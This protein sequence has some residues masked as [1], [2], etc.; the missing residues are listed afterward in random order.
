MMAAKHILLCIALLPMWALPPAHEATA[1]QVNKCHCI[2]RG[3][4]IIK[5][6]TLILI[7]NN[8]TDATPT[9]LQL[10]Q[11]DV[12]EIGVSIRIMDRIGSDYDTLGTH[13]LNDEDGGI[14]RTIEHDKNKVTG[15]ILNEVFHRWI[16]GQGQKNGKK[17]NTWEMLVKYLKHVKLMALADEIEAVLQ[18]CTEKTMHLNDEECAHEY[19]ERM[20]EALIETKSLQ[21]L[22]SMLAAVII[23]AAIFHCRRK[24]NTIACH[25]LINWKW[26]WGQGQALAI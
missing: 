8:S 3:K 10:T 9:M 19:G 16:K 2:K 4:P 15:K 14:M 21:Y 11:L 25:Q 24:L 26:A 13:L 6:S 20:H 12:L 23:G 5:V 22:I 18:F 1:Y 17:T 7:D